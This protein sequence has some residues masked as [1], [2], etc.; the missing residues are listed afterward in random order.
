MKILLTIEEYA[1]ESARTIQTVY[2]KIKEGKLKSVKIGSTQ[3]IDLLDMKVSE[4]DDL[5]KQIRKKIYPF[6]N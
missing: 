2:R 5:N 4:F 1:E 6:S 3:Y